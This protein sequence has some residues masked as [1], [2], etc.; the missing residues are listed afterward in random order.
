[1]VKIC[2]THHPPK[3][4][5]KWCS[6]VTDI[7]HRPATHAACDWCTPVKQQRQTPL[8][9]MCRPTLRSSTATS[10]S[11]CTPWPCSLTARCS[12]PSRHSS[13]WRRATLALVTAASTRRS[14][15]R[16]SS[17]QVCVPL[18]TLQAVHRHARAVRVLGLPSRTVLGCGL[19]SKA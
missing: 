3:K 19:H 4:N 6:A 7:R 8:L 16:V 12:L 14:A 2:V 15:C 9:Q 11:S 13:R 1:M 5:P 10:T 18:W 17:A